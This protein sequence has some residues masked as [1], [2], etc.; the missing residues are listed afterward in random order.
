MVKWEGYSLADNTWEPLTSIYKD[1]SALCR[2][3]FRDKGFTLKCKCRHLARFNDFLDDVK[4]PMSQRFQL[5]PLLKPV[6]NKITK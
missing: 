3:Y 5:T 6:T 2:R 4:L 1:I